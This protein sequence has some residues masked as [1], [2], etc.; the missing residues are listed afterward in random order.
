MSTLQHTYSNSNLRTRMALAVVLAG[1]IT[2][3]MVVLISSGGG[4]ANPLSFPSGSQSAPS[5]AQI[6]RQLEAVAGPRY[7]VVRATP[8]V[9]AANVPSGSPR[10][11]LEAV[12]GARYNQPVGIH[13]S[14]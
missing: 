14:R 3:L 12:A 13:V 9:P 1:T 4:R 6:Q 8:A 11:Q 2:A 10:R 5:Q 7:G